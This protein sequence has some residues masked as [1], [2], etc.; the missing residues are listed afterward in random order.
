MIRKRVRVYLADTRGVALVEYGIAVGLTVLVAA[1]VFTLGN[2][3]EEKLR[4]A[5]SQ[6]SGEEVES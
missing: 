1:A 2:K 4:E 3:V 5:E 6:L